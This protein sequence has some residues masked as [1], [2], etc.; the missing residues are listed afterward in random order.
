MRNKFLGASK[1]K[2]STRSKRKINLPDVKEEVMVSK[3]EEGEAS[4]VQFYGGS[5]SLLRHSEEEFLEAKNT[6]EVCEVLGLNFN[7]DKEVILNRF[8]KME[9]SLDG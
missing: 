1:Q 3:A 7:A 4:P 8:V 9:K 6:M 2:S 5:E